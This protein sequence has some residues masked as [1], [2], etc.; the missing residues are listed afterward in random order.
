MVF[1]GGE[2]YRFEGEGNVQINLLRKT[3]VFLNIHYILGMDKNTLSI[4]KIMD[5][6]IHLHVI[7]SDHKCCN[8]G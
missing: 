6:N 8:F 5:Q 1:G 3:L 4:S 2:E 7:L